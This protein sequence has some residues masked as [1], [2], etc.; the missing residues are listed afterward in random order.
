MYLSYHMT[1]FM[2][3]VEGIQEEDLKLVRIYL[4]LILILTPVNLVRKSFLS[5]LM[6]IG[7]FYL[8][9]HHFLFYKTLN[10]ILFSRQNQLYKLV[11][12]IYRNYIL[13]N[14]LYSLH[15]FMFNLV[16]ILDNNN[17]EAQ[18]AYSVELQHL[19]TTPTLPTVL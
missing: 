16:H 11:N 15:T 18:Y 13:I 9:M 7:M 3:Y 19:P 5:C 8:M 12:Y 6:I 1:I 4:L 10:D 17:K 2:N 14:L